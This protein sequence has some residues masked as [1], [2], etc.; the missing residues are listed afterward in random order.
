MP[1]QNYEMTGHGSEWI[2]TPADSRPINLIHAERPSYARCRAPTCQHHV[3]AGII[4][5]MQVCS[6]ATASYGLD[7]GKYTLGVHA[8]VCASK[9]TTAWARLTSGI[10]SFD[11][12]PAVGTK[13]T[14]ITELA[15]CINADL[16]SG[17]SVALGL[18]AP[19][20]FP[21]ARRHKESLHLFKGRFPE[22][23]ECTRQWYL[24]GGTAATLKALSLG[25]MLLSLV[26][27]DNPGIRL[28][29]QPN[30]IAQ[31]T[32]VLF[33]AFVTAD[34]KLSE[35]RSRG[36]TEHEWDAFLASLAW[37]AL[38]KSFRVPAGIARRVLHAAG[39]E[40][41]ETLS[42]W[43]TIASN[44]PSLLPVDGPPDCDVVALAE[45]PNLGPSR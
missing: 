35:Y 28:T 23:D 34:F 13:G 1:L 39:R 37:G 27:D 7:I 3:R 36:I 15:R 44:V 18:E 45:N 4:N 21:I 14:S 16:A 41:A 9:T 38:R 29:T 32:L 20:W 5:R 10:A 11:E 2:F 17:R 12:L 42:I 22:E 31:N 24:N 43:G 33:E 6:S 25:I 30:C 40:Q 26:R 8:Q 19:M